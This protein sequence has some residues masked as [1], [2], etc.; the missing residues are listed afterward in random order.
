M[1]RDAACR[2][3]EQV[4]DIEK[5]SFPK[6][7]SRES[8]LAEIERERGIFKVLEIEGRVAGYFVIWTVLDEAELANIAV[9][10]EHR[11]RGLGKLLLANAV[12]S[13]KDAKEVFLEVA[14]EN[15]PAILLYE[16]YGFK[17]VGLIR[18]YYGQGKDANIMKF[19]IEEEVNDVENRL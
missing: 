16:S 8:F 15:R 10:P 18:S 11:G 12:A 3:L 7:W 19:S 6:P 17:K 13:A 5:A 14:V 9:S 4:C 1:I 2:D